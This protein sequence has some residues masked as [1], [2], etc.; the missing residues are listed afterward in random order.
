MTK[1]KRSKKNSIISLILGIIGIILTPILFFPIL[2]VGFG[3]VGF[4]ILKKDE[5]NEKLGKIALAACLISLIIGI[6]IYVVK[7]F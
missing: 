6:V 7:L 4:L 2:G 5:T 3:I 1:E